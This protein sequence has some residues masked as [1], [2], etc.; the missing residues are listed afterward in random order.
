MSLFALCTDRNRRVLVFGG[1]GAL[2]A[3]SDAIEPEHLLLA[4]VR[5]ADT[6]WPEGKADE[7]LPLVEPVSIAA[8][9]LELLGIPLDALGESPAD[10]LGPVPPLGRAANRIVRYEAVLAK[11]AGDNYL[12]TG[13][14][15]LALYDDRR[16]APRRI[17]EELGVADRDVLAAAVREADTGREQRLREVARLAARNPQVHEGVVTLASGTTK[18]AGFVRRRIERQLAELAELSHRRD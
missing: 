12:S 7:P 1:Q 14:Q 9:A 2:G 16:S 17:L 6:P 4:I 5:D 13:H 10:A 11:R 15:L 3:G 8:R 18:P